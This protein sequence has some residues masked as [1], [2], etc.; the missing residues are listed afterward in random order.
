[1]GVKTVRMPGMLRSSINVDPELMSFVN[2]LIFMTF[3][4]ESGIIG[5]VFAGVGQE[6]QEMMNASGITGSKYTGQALPPED[7][8]SLMRSNISL[9]LNEGSY[10]E[11]K[12]KGADVSL[13]LV[14]QTSRGN[15]VS[16]SLRVRSDAQLITGEFSGS[17]MYSLTATPT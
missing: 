11:G 13:R 5:S 15:V 14:E 7:I 6:V 1:M 17:I 3:Y 16:Y 8:L 12:V 4:S 10:K 2:D 9:L